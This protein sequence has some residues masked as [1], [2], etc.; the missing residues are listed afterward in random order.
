MLYIQYMDFEWDS[1]KNEANI[2]KH[3]IDFSGAQTIWDGYVVTLQSIQKYHGEIRF[4]AIGLYK[5]REIT[6]VY[7][8]RDR[9]RRLISARRARKNEREIYW[10]NTGQNGP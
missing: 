9:K 2:K 6:V 7:T 4:L 3:G 8:Q 10:K 1:T 5:G